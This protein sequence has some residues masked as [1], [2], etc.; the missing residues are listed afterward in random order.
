M[1]KVCSRLNIIPSLCG[2][3]PVSPATPGSHLRSKSGE[4]RSH[5]ETPAEWGNP[6]WI[7][8]CLLSLLINR[9]L[10]LARV[11][12]RLNSGHGRIP[13]QVNFEVS[14]SCALQCTPSRL[15][16]P[17]FHRHRPGDH[18]K[19][20]P[21]VTGS[22]LEA[23][24]SRL[25]CGREPPGSCEGALAPDLASGLHSC[26]VETQDDFCRCPAHEANGDS[27]VTAP[28][29][30]RSPHFSNNTEDTPFI[31]RKWEFFRQVHSLGRPE[32]MPIIGGQVPRNSRQKHRRPRPGQ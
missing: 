15:C 9:P 20:C 28:G 8:N 32:P 18:L 17:T 10:W 7:S 1:A 29:P 2:W 27:W 13:G 6:L 31:P 3:R 16:I 25:V 22:R 21:L 4:R 5:G 23:H 14:S 26:E 30:G 24:R 19:F 11:F 12:N